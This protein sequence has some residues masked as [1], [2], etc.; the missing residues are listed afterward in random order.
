MS[1]SMWVGML[2]GTGAH[3]EAEHLLVDLPVGVT[4][5]DGV[6]HDVQRHFGDRPAELGSTT[7]KSTCAT[8]PRTG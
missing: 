1:T 8:V 2:V 6:A 7:W 4:D 5:L 3:L